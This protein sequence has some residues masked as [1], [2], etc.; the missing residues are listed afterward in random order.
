M[1]PERTG[2][3]PPA[4]RSTSGRKQKHIDI[5]YFNQR[6]PT[7]QAIRFTPNTLKHPRSPKL[8]VLYLFTTDRPNGPNSVWC[9]NYTFERLC[10]HTFPEMPSVWCQNR[11]HSAFALRTISHAWRARGLQQN[12]SSSFSFC[13]TMRTEKHSRCS[14]ARALTRR[15]HSEQAR[16]NS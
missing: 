6:R 4:S 14:H 2:C 9:R 3:R 13:Q 11:T 7:L 1:K 5:P 16:T 15:E 8:N 10:C 12:F